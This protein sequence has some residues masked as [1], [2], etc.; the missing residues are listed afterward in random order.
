MKKMYLSA[1]QL[2]EDS[3]HLACQVLESGYKPDLIAGVWRGGAPVAIAIQ[4]TLALAGMACDHIAIRAASYTG[5]NQRTTVKVDGLEY[6]HQ[7]L[8]AESRLLIVDDVFDTGLSIKQILS[9]L[10]ALFDDKPPSIR[11]ATAYYKP[12]NNLTGRVPDYYCQECDQWLVFPH[13]LLGLTV[14]EIMN[15]PVNT[16]ILYKLGAWLPDRG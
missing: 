8:T 12:A 16:D 2:L 5:I 10:N 15:K 3:L 11:I 9:E 4:E 7:H 1:Q 13:E 6:I 14:G